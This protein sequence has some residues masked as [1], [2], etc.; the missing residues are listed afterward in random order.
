M[1]DSNTLIEL[2]ECI[3]GWRKDN[4]SYN[5]EL[6]S[7]DLAKFAKYVQKQISDKVSFSAPNNESVLILYT[8]VYYKDVDQFC[9]DNSDFYYISNTDASL[10]W[11]NE[12]QVAINEV[13]TG[14]HI[15]KYDDF[16]E[17]TKKFLEVK[18]LTINVLTNTLLKAIVKYLR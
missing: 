11:E 7:S 15:E 5:D 6:S 12:F 14:S 10:L 1:I 2:I 13:I 8:G 16:P 3:Y 9:K 4:I 18:I 17:T